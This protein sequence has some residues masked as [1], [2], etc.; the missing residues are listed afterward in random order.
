MYTHANGLKRF[1]FRLLPRKSEAIDGAP[2][3]YKELI[4][5]IKD[6]VRRGSFIIHDGWKGTEK[7]LKVLKFKTAPAVKHKVTFRDAETGFHTNDVESENK[8][9]KDWARHHYSRL[10]ITIT[11]SNTHFI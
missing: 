2:R 5:P 9:L 8:R 4:P 11:F 1:T 6:H 10:L 3:G 7:A